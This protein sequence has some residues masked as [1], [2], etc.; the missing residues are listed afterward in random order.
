MAAGKTLPALSNQ[1]R[2]SCAQHLGIQLSIRETAVE[3][4]RSWPA[5]GRHKSLNVFEHC[6]ITGI[7]EY[8]LYI[9]CLLSA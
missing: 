9:T 7:L 3:I 8:I 6:K 4:I 1:V 5:K 2:L